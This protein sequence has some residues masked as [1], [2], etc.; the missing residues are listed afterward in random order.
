MEKLFCRHLRNAHKNCLTECQFADDTA[1]L[2]TTR[3]RAENPLE[4]YVEVHLARDFGLTISA[5]K[6]KDMVCGRQVVSN[7]GLPSKLMRTALR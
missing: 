5:A 1:L 7:D 3:E 4:A 2:A 6:T